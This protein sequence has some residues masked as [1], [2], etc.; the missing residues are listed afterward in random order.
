MPYPIQLNL[1]NVFVPL[2]KHSRRETNVLKFPTLTLTSLVEGGGKKLLP[3]IVFSYSF[4]LHP[5]L[6]LFND[7]CMTPT[8]INN[9]ILNMSTFLVHVDFIFFHSK[10]QQC[11]CGFFIPMC[12][13][14]VQTWHD[15]L[16]HLWHKPF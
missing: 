16:P 2:T 15:E 5:T 8:S 14:L 1:F 4:T 7:S 12:I 6:P 10:V 9:V 11:F 3:I 13:S